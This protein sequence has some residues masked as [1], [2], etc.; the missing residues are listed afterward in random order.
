[1]VALLYLNIF[2]IVK[3][4]GFLKELMLNPFV[5][6]DIGNRHIC[7]FTQ[8]VLYQGP[9]TKFTETIVYIE[10]ICSSCSY[11]LWEFDFSFQL[12]ALYVFLK[13]Y[14]F[15]LIIL[16]GAIWSAILDK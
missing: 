15:V 14:S 8:L 3:R 6:F 9:G 5:D 7:V 1:M 13:I 12:K 11:A 4:C 10:Y 16:T 2:P